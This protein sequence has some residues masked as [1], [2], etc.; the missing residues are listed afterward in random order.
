M[1]SGLASRFGTRGASSQRVGLSAITARVKLSKISHYLVDNVYLMML[2]DLWHPVKGES[3]D[4]TDDSGN[5]L[6]RPVSLVCKARA[7]LAIAF[8]VSDRVSGRNLKEV[9]QYLDRFQ[10]FYKA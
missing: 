4:V 9:G 6:G 7:G 2:S 10:S 1:R 3:R 8:T 5:S